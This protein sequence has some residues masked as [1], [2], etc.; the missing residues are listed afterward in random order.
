MAE[1]VVVVCGERVGDSDAVVP[2][3][4]KVREGAASG[5]VE[6]VRVDVVLEDLWT[7]V[8]PHG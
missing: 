5:G 8:S 6:E 4:M 2:G 1:G 3:F 7:L